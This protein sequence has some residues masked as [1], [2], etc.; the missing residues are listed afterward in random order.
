M[1]K[2]L[3]SL[4]AVGVLSL[5]FAGNAGAFT[6]HSSVKLFPLS[7]TLAPQG[8]KNVNL[9]S[10]LATRDPDST[11]P[12]KKANPVGS[13][14]MKFPAGSAVNKS[15]VGS[16]NVCQQ[17]EYATPALLASACANAVIGTGWA[18]LNDG[19]ALPSVHEQVDGAPPACSGDKLVGQYTRTWEADPAAGPDCVP[20]GDVFVKVTAYQGGVLK[21]GYWCYGM[22]SVAVGFN[23]K[24]PNGTPKDCYFKAP[25]GKKYNFSGGYCK[26]ATSNGVSYSL[27]VINKPGPAFGCKSKSDIKWQAG[28]YDASANGCNIIFA[29]DNSAAKLSFGG[30]TNGCGNVLSVVIPSLNG[31]GAGLGELT[32]GFVLTD[33]YLKTN[34]ATYLKAGT[35]PSNKTFKVTTDFTYSVLK[36]ESGLPASNP[37]TKSVDYTGTCR[38]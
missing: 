12:M 25:N 1:R 23:P 19:N 2:S 5:A 13:V 16:G 15:A 35:C 20:V 14:N 17:S 22:D 10:Y 3:S 37:A 11:R 18:L 9:D 28:A 8:K 6:Q 36:G 34:N 21:S 7:G 33:F 32:G 29:N 27:D 38:S 30:S 4:A 31:T 26:T 24:N